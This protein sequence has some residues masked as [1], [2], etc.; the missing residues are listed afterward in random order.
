M[1]RPGLEDPARPV[2]LYDLASPLCW[3]AAEDVGGGPVWQPVSLQD[4][5]PDA[6]AAL[7][8]V[9]REAIAAR[10]PMPLR[11]PDPYPADSRTAMLAAAF[12]KKSG[13]AVAFSLAAFRQA[14]AAGKDLGEPDNVLIAGAACEL[15]PRALL[16]GLELRGTRAELDAGTE[17]ARD[18]GVAELP[19][20]VLGDRVVTGLDAIAAA[21]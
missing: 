9:D 3:L 4:L 18:R 12:A 15:H 1:P 6:H 2:F 7:A 19:A 11:W 8:G 17:L 20:L 5:S 21:R 14:F 10:A 16:Q 13:R